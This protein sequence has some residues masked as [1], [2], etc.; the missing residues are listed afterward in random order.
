MARG[1]II[2]MATVLCV[3]PAFLIIFP[4]GTFPNEASVPFGKKS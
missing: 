2:S 3:L 4:L 1:A